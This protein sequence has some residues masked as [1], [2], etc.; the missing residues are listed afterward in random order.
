MM[1]R[2]RSRFSPLAFACTLGL[3]ALPAGLAAQELLWSEEFDSGSQPSPDVWSYDLGTGNNGWGNW[4]LQ[5]YTD[6]PANA[7]VEN[8]NLVITA[9]PTMSGNEVIGFT[10]ARIRTQDKLMFRYGRIEARIKAPNLERGLWPAFWTLGNNFPD[11]GW[12]ACGELDIMEMGMFDAYSAGPGNVNQWVSSAAHWES[13]DNYAIYNRT[14]KTGTNLTEDYHILTMDWTPTLVTTYLDGEEIWAMDISS[15]SCSDCEE[16]HRPHFVILNMAVG[17]TFTGMRSI[18]AITAPLPAS[19]LVDYVRIYDNGYTELSGTALG[20]PDIG[21][22]H[23]GSW[24]NASQSGHGFSVEFGELGDGSPLAVIYWYIYNDQGEP[25]FMLGTGTPEGNQ[26][27]VDFQSPVGMVYGVFDKE[28]VERPSGG[29]GVFV[30]EDRDNATFSYTPSEFS[31]ATWGH[32][33]PIDNLPLTK[34]FGIPAEPAFSQPQA[35]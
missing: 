23:S 27:T 1:F 2:T 3:T 30:F 11:V 24:Y 26:V 35:R 22:A 12:P 29:T 34:L 33:T 20:P 18:G 6:L 9:R 17:G 10:S 5:T 7:A 32:T 19:M 14:L 31:T 16:F 4:E 21:P 13:S 15:G 8:G 25:I 28:T